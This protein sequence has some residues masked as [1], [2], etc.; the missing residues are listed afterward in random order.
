MQEALELR[1]QGIDVIDLGP[2]EPD[3]PTPSS[4][5]QAGIDAVASDFTKYTPA[6]G[7]KELRESLA[8][9]L[10]RKWGTRFSGSNV[11]VTCGAKHAI[12]NVCMTV[13]EEGHEVLN[14]CP[15]WVTFPEVVK[16]TGARPVKVETTEANGFVL[17]TSAVAEKLNRRTKGLIVNTPN[18]PTGALIPAETL[19]EL[20][21]LVRAR[22]IFLIFDE[23]YEYL[24]YEGKKHTSLAS[25]VDPSTDGFALVGSFSKTYSMTGWR[26]GYCVG[27][28]ELIEKMGQLQSHQTGNPTSISQKAAVEALTGGTRELEIMRLEY[29]RRRRLVLDDIARIPG[30]RCAPP[31]G[32]FYVFPNVSQAMEK[33]GISTSQEFS[34][35]LLQEARVATVPGSAFGIEGY[36][37]ISY[38]TSGETLREGLSRIKRAVVGNTGNWEPRS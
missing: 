28:T 10:N 1:A 24:T 27:P 18:N 36:I 25:C 33:L 32:A 8:E 9:D 2:G 34:K 35:F 22:D 21:D 38:A 29:E 12:F 26:I 17:T 20:V 6:S 19:K 15:Y 23:T 13:F 5:K 14:P 37:R 30:F 31:Y 11:I 16:M 3:F 7:I 4:I